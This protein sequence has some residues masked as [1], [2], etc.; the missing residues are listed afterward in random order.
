MELAH[1]L[2][3]IEV[4]SYLAA[5][6]DSAVAVDASIGYDQVLLEIDG[7]HG[8]DIPATRTVTVGD[9][10]RMFAQAESAIEDLSRHG[11][12]ALTIELVLDMLHLA[13]DLDRP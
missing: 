1:A 7:I 3:L 9:R 12:D 2:T 8:D 5:L 4:R 10:D 6:A 13:W 11:I